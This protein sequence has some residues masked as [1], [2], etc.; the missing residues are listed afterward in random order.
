[1]PTK[2]E[3]IAVLDKEIRFLEADIRWHKEH[4]IYTKIDERILN[5]YKSI[6]SIVEQ[7][8]GEQNA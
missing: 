5:I 2:A 8:E 6:R 7:W 3:M 4:N 1:M